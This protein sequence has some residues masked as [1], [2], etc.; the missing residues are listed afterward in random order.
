MQRHRRVLES[1]VPFVSSLKVLTIVQLPA[2]NDTLQRF[3]TAAEC[4]VED[5]EVPNSIALIKPT[6][7]LK[8]IPSLPHARVVAVCTQQMS[9]HQRSINP[10]EQQAIYNLL[11]SF[12]SLGTFSNEM[13]KALNIRNLLLNIL[14]E[15]GIAVKPYEYPEPLQRNAS[16]LLERLEIEIAVEEMDQSKVSPEPGPTQAPKRRRKS[17]VQSPALEMSRLSIENSSSHFKDIMRGIAITG[18]SR[19]VYKRDQNYRPEPR[20]CKVVGNNGLVVGDWWPLRICAIRDGAHGA[21]QAGIAY[22]AEVGA[23]S[24][25]VSGTSDLQYLLRVSVH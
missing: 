14:G 5:E 25:V 1:L 11:K 21:M 2:E 9:K 10:E 17:K 12:N 22:S 15:T 23:Y 7:F 13:V 6:G 8:S 19:R 24:V 3:A 4:G 18:G 16:I 20:N